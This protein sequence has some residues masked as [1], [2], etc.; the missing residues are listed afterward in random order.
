MGPLPRVPGALALIAQAA[1]F[2]EFL[3]EEQQHAQEPDLP[4]CPA[5]Q[6]TTP[7][8]WN[9]ARQ[10]DDSDIWTWAEGSEFGSL[11]RARVFE[12]ARGS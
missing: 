8:S 2:E 1:D 5:S 10:G 9:A 11:V 3:M 7:E 12:L 6:L 4:T